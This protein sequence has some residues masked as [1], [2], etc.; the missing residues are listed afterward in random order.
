MN[1]NEIAQAALDGKISVTEAFMLLGRIRDTN[2][3]K[4]ISNRLSIAELNR[5]EASQ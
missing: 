2:P 5:E 4:D 1:A 3:I